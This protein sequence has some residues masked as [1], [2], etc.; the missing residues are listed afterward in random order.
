[1]KWGPKEQAEAHRVGE[2][3][4]ILCRLRR[5]VWSY[6]GMVQVKAQGICLPSESKPAIVCLNWEIRVP[7]MPEDDRAAFFDKCKQLVFQEIRQM[8]RDVCAVQFISKPRLNPLFAAFHE[9][10]S[11]AA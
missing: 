8:F 2:A 5:H 3:R 11:Q 10:K 6:N 4:E 9:E 7:N 1:M